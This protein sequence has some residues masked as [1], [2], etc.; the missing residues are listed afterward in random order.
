MHEKNIFRRKNFQLYGKGNI[1]LELLS[2]GTGYI[3]INVG[4]PYESCGIRIKNVSV[5]SFLTSGTWVWPSYPFQQGQKPLHPQW[6][7]LS[8][9][10][11]S[12]VDGGPAEP[13]GSGGPVGAFVLVV[14]GTDVSL[15]SPAVPCPGVSVQ[16]HSSTGSLLP[17]LFQGSKLFHWMGHRDS[18]LW[19]CTRRKQKKR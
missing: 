17:L 1:S 9:R 2:G 11:V 4:L 18:G 8:R 14:P 7:V 3:F 19:Q 6:T 16:T 15:T 10:R 12:I 5:R 13:W